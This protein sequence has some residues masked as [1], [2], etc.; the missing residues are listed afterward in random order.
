VERRRSRWALVAWSL[1]LGLTIA[2]F[3]ALGSGPLAAPPVSDPGA[4]GAW[5]DGREPVTAAVALLRLVVLALAWYLL[6]VTVLAV[7]ARCTRAVRVIR[8]ADALAV[9]AVRRLVRGAVG[10]SLAT[11]MVASSTAAVASPLPADPGVPPGARTGMVAL[12]DPSPD[13]RPGE[14]VPDPET[15]PMVD[16]GPPATHL[17]PAEDDHDAGDEDVAG[18]VGVE[19]GGDHP[20]G[21][22]ASEGGGGAEHTVTSGEHLW[23]IAAATLA[24]ELGRAPSEGEVVPYWQQL[25]ATNRDVLADPANPDLLFPGQL[26]TLPPVPD[27]APS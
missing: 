26:L 5:L 1:S 27:G 12:D 16:L 6:A 19:V 4:F 10:V 21:G 2:G 20:E 22:G 3:T 17:D 25:I 9:P 15:T 14:E 13:H 23:A 18:A 8:F 7:L 11:G 24:D